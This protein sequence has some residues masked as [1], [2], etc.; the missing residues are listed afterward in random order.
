MIRIRQLFEIP[1]APSN[2]FWKSVLFPFLVT[3]SV[4]VFV[5]YFVTGNYS[6]NPSYEIYARRGYFLTR[7]FPLDIFARWD[8]RWYFSIIKDGYQASADL[9]T[10]YSNMAFFP[11]YPDLVKSLGWFGIDMPDGYYILA[12]LI[13]SNLFFLASALLL[14][15][16]ITGPLEFRH[17]TAQ[18]ALGLLFVFPA[19][20][21]FSSFYPESLFL[22]LA[23][24]GFTFALQE[25]WFLAGICM[26]LAV[27]TKSQGVVLV[28]A[29]GWLY[30][31]KRNWNPRNIRPSLAWFALAPLALSLHF[32][33]LYLRSGHVLAVFD[34]MSAWGRG[35]NILNNPFQNLMR[36][37]LDVFKIDLVLSILFLAGSLYLLW[38]WPIK[39]YGVFALLM[40]LMPISTGLLVSVSRYLVIIFPVFILLGEKI[41]NRNWYDFARAGLFAIQII[42]FAGWVNYYWIA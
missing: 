31:E 19:S 1:N 17:A 24:A 15:R 38:K 36:P 4:W 7:I 41:R 5:A 14:Y 3:R 21:F 27:L 20:F 23:L 40:N 35:Q 16:L 25:K 28:F 22:F 13:L 42:Y 39:A 18:R 33:F 12:G 8:S 37:S 32:Y 29:L 2:W 9:K 26:A 34:A 30:M 6:P 11:L 10:A